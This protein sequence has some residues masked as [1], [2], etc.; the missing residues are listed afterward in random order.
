MSERSLLLVAGL[1]LGVCGDPQGGDDTDVFTF[2][3][4]PVWTS[5]G[6][7]FVSFNERCAAFVA[8]EVLVRLAPQQREAFEGWADHIGFTI[9][10]SRESSSGVTMTVGVPEGSV[11]DAVRLIAQQPGAR[12]SEPSYLGGLPEDPSLGELLGCT[13]VPTEDRP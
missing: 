4:V 2:T 12:I 7:P 9:R 13:P 11:P 10:S 6:T 1:L 3:P 8:D 5:V